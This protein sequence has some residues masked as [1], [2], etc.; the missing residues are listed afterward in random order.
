MKIVTLNSN[1]SVNK[2][3]QEERLEIA[4]KTFGRSDQCISESVFKLINSL[5]LPDNCSILELG[6]GKGNLLSMIKNNYKN[7]NISA[8]DIEKF[9]DLSLDRI[10]FIQHDLNHNLPTQLHS[11]FNLVIIN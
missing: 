1:L 5:D 7:W 10:E 6:C 11:Q 8:L 4:R 9:K 3:L 2:E